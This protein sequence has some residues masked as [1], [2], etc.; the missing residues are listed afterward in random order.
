[1]KYTIYKTCNLFF[2]AFLATS[3]FAQPYAK[4]TANGILLD[5]GVV[6]RY[7]KLSSSPGQ[8]STANLC[9]QGDSIGFVSARTAAN[10]DAELNKKS[11]IKESDS[12]EF[13]FELDG[14]LIT[15][16]SG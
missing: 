13:S 14:K 3:L 8:I 15:G 5:N 12:H 4:W 2:F 11:S 9:M 16:K 10:E 6:S 7:I 1:M